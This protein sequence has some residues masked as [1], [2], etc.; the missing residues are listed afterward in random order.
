LLD[1]SPAAAVADELEV[2]TD[3]VAPPHAPHA[4]SAIAVAIDAAPL[5]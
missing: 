5:R 1:T 4:P 2:A 3:R